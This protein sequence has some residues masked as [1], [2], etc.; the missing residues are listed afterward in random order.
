[1]LSAKETNMALSGP[2]QRELVDLRGR[3][4]RFVLRR[5]FVLALLKW[6]GHTLPS[7]PARLN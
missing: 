3:V 2:E 5:S 1:M 6:R 7:I 4:D